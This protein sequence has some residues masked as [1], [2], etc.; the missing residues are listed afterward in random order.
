ME[1]KDDV[2]LHVINN[3]FSVGADAQVSLEFHEG[4]GWFDT[5]ICM[6]IYQLMSQD[7]SVHS[8]A[9]PQRYNSRFI[10]KFTYSKVW[11]ST[12]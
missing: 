3:Y 9:N 12:V 8:E 11:Q 2:P 6:K 4:R 7:Y 1:G 10:N 5:C